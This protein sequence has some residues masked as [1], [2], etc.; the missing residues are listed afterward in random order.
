MKSV[1]GGS[2]ISAWNDNL[3]DD[4]F[5]NFLPSSLP[6]TPQ[7]STLKY[8]NPEKKIVDKRKSL[9]V[10]QVSLPFLTLRGK[11]FRADQSR[12]SKSQNPLK[13]NPIPGDITT[14]SLA[15]NQTLYAT[16]EADE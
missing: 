13:M 15:H 4:S 2:S 10:I 16:E 14:Y 3:E 6:S 5:Q 11:V 1:Q 9:P 8:I 7:S 12:G